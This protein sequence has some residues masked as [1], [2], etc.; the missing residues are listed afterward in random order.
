MMAAQ[1]Y[2]AMRKDLPDIDKQISDGDFDE[3][4]HWLHANIYQHGRLMSTKD[5]L[6]KATGK[7][8]RAEYLEKH[9]RAR[10][11]S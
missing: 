6:K 10:Y 11:L 8:L 2:Y 3:I 7:S 1:L 9:L 5:M 4:R